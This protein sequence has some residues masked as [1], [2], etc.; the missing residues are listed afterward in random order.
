MD[1]AGKRLS[2]ATECGFRRWTLVATEAIPRQD[3]GQEIPSTATELDL[4]KVP[5]G[6]TALDNGHVR[7]S[8]KRVRGQEGRSAVLQLDRAT[9]R[10][11]DMLVLGCTWQEPDAV[12]QPWRTTATKTSSDE[13]AQAAWCGR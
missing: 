7:L 8:L 12:L 4:L 10:I 13:D 9:Q 2:A 6:P 11:G 5:L 1:E 3:L